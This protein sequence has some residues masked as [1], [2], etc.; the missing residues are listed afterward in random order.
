M[1]NGSPYNQTVAFD[2]ITLAITSSNPAVG[3][4]TT[5]SAFIDQNQYQTFAE[6]M[7]IAPGTFT[8]RVEP[9]S[10]NVLYGIVVSDPITVTP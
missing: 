1:P 6:A 7:A 2:V 3:I 5:P 10:G 9:L 8:I 4:I